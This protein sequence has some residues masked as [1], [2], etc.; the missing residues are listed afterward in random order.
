MGLPQFKS[1]VSTNQIV[2]CIL[3]PTI[4]R[5]LNAATRDE[6]ITGPRNSLDKTEEKCVSW[7]GVESN[8]LPW[9]HMAVPCG[10]QKLFCPYL[11]HIITV[12]KTLYRQL[13]LRMEL[14]QAVLVLFRPP[15]LGG[16]W[17]PSSTLPW[18]D[19][20]GVSRY[21]GNDWE[22]PGLEGRSPRFCLASFPGSPH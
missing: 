7:K 16:T 20:P 1:H 11:E 12:F 6:P 18:W 17:P 13:L 2:D 4:A 9:Q 21:T 22:L 5:K 15:V 14:I 19:L 8:T 3:T 10:N